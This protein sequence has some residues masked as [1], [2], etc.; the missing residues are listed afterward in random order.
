MSLREEYNADFA[1]R[2]PEMDPVVNDTI[3]TMKR[4]QL[5]AFLWEMAEL[6]IV[7]RDPKEMTPVEKYY[8]RIKLEDGNKWFFQVLED[9]SPIALLGKILT[10]TNYG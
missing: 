9:N 4:E 1:A 3:K 2:K 8:E 6:S 5:S 7:K 10:T